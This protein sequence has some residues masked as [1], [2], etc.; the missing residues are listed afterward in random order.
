MWY[1]FIK[2]S[3]TNTEALYDYSYESKETSGT[4]SFS[5]ETEEITFKKLANG[6][7]GTQ[8]NRFGGAFR[9]RVKDEGFP[10]MMVLAFG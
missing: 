6:D 7:D 10:E 2:K 5:K 4:L 9:R 1:R 3:E 8:V